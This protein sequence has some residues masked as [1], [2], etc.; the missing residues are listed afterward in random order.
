MTLHLNCVLAKNMALDLIF[1]L[2]YFKIIQL[3]NANSFVLLTPCIFVLRNIKESGKQFCRY[4]REIFLDNILIWKLFL[5]NKGKKKR[6]GKKLMNKKLASGD[7]IQYFSVRFH[8]EF[9]FG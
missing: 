7:T 4:M 2:C 3:Q 9:H 6:A 8:P 5:L 1:H